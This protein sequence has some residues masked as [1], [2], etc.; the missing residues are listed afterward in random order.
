MRVDGQM[1]AAGDGQA[2]VSSQYFGQRATI[3]R[4][5]LKEERQDGLKKLYERIFTNR[6]GSGVALDHIE[7]SDQT[8]RFDLALDLKVTHLGQNMMGKMLVVKPGSLAPDHGYNFPKIE[9]KQPIDLSAS[10][11]TDRITLKLPEGYAIDEM[12][13]P[14]NLT[15]PFGTYHASW[16]VA[17]GVVTMEQSLEVKSITAPASDYAKVR[18]F[19]DHVTGGQFAPVV[20]MKK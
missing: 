11:R 20:L 13:D 9:R 7:P 17:D 10:M 18:D 16:K 19:F 14:V 15:G 5:V 2:H 8:S 6:L 1:N 4:A 3:L 12:P